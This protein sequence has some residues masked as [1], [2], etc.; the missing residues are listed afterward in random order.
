M[1]FSGSNNE[2]NFPNRRELP[3]A[4]LHQHTWHSNEGNYVE[5]HKQTA[6]NPF[7]TLTRSFTFT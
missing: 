3:R 2:E 1:A 4:D 5:I 6:A 7:E